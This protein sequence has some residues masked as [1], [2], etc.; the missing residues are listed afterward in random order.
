[1]VHKRQRTGSGR[2]IEY[3]LRRLSLGLYCQNG[4]LNGNILNDGTLN[5]GHLNVGHLNM[6]H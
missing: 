3:W 5:I 1:V 4:T 2:Q 6:G